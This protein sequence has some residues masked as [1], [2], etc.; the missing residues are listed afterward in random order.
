MAAEIEELV[1]L[2]PESGLSIFSDSN[3]RYAIPLY[4]R[5]Y[6]WSD[7]EIEQ[8][9]DDINDAEE[10]SDRYYIGSLIVFE[11][12]NCYEV[13]DGQQRLTTLMLLLAYL[14][15]SAKDMGIVLQNTLSYDCRQRATKTFSRLVDGKNVPVEECDKALLDGYAVI[16]NKFKA[17]DVDVFVER[18]SKV[19]IFRIPVPEETDLNRYFE[20]MNTRGEQLEQ[21]DVLK[22][23][24]MSSINGNEGKAEFARIWEACSDMS[25]YVQMHFD[26][27]T[28]ERFFGGEWR[29]LAADV[30]LEKGK[31][32]PKETPSLEQI[33]APGFT[34]DTSDGQSD[35]YDRV[36]FES[37][38]EFPYFL[39]HVLKVFVQDKKVRFDEGFE[40]RS[41]IDDKHLADEFKK[42]MVHG[43]I[44]G[45]A[46]GENLERFS[47]DFVLCLLKCRYLFDKYI[48][49][50]EY[51]NE[52]SDGEWSLKELRASGQGRNKK[53]YYRN[54]RIALKGERG[55]TSDA[56]NKKSLMLQSALRVSYTS[57]KVMHW[58]TYLLAWLYA[59]E[60]LQRLDKYC[61]VTKDF[62]RSAIRD[63]LADENRDCMGVETPRVVFNYLDYLLWERNDKVSFVFEFRNSVEHWYPRNPSE[64]TFE[65]WNQADLDSFGNLCIVTRSVNSRFSNMAPMAKRTTFEDM[66]AKGSLKLREM[67]RLTT[68]NS[69]WLAAS[70][71]HGE[72]MLALL[73]TDALVANKALFKEEGE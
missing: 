54:T 63:Y 56:R 42:V 25:G 72:E 34:C 69:D 47:V 12:G 24:L 57:P 15:D 61:D 31:V 20:I 19:R 1:I 68:G 18:L 58:I 43:R 33:L 37:I 44:G 67:S 9:I 27:E 26:V 48:I 21:H 35:K 3:I 22:A 29:Y 45:E 60:N 55:T 11:R 52:A 32:T 62:V 2:D 4:Q 65:K 10:G 28:R 73:A 40:L 39:L 6:S 7:I 50:R 64:D 70:R 59:G 8:L 66:I 16:E 51:A 23:Q 30:K 71:K 46:I 36:R 41:L 38:I 14:R 53:A 5:A 49:K 13:I 17:I